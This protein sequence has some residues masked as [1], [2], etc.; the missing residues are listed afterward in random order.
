MTL[1][2]A[3]KTNLYIRYRVSFIGYY[4]RQNL[5]L[6]YLTENKIN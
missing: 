3:Q 5:Q 6:G 1:S 4:G 2:A